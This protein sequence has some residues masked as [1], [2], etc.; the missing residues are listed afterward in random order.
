M[1]SYIPVLQL[2]G[3]VLLSLGVISPETVV[4]FQE[5]LQAFVEKEPKGPLA[6]DAYRR[7]F[8]P[9]RHYL[10]KLITGL[11]AFVFTFYLA[12]L[13]VSLG[14]LF[15][16]IRLCFVIEQMAWPAVAYLLPGILVLVVTGFGMHLLLS[17]LGA[18]PK[19]LGSFSS[20]LEWLFKIWWPLFFVTVIILS[21]LTILLPHLWYRCLQAVHKRGAGWFFAI[22]GFFILLASYFAQTAG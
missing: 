19:V 21:P 2:V 17:F 16:S 12:V 20:F 14:L 9:K 1:T 7:V 18:P 10:E 3:T 4:N 5:K 8:D 22:L 11:T 13:L 15:V 6:T